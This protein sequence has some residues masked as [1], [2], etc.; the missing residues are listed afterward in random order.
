MT[1]KVGD[2]LPNTDLMEM[3]QSGPSKVSSAD[4][5]GGKKVAM[6]AVPGAYTPTCSAKHL[7][8]FIANLDVLKAKGVDSIICL[9]VNDPFVMAAWG[10]DQNAGEV[11]MIADPDGAFTKAMQLEFDASGAGLGI[12]SR[13]YSMVAEDGVVSVLNL[14]ET[15][16]FEVSDAETLVG[17]I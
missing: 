8:G 15:G 4:L 11:R 16:G 5:F 7:P 17:Q 12:R 10:K 14:E 2:K 9:S 13:R 3:T 6:F 1:L